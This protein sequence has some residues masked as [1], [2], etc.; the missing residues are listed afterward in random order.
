MLVDS[1][2]HLDA[3]E[4][5]GDRAAVLGAARAAGVGG[6]LVPGVERAGFAGLAALA[7]AEA[8]IAPAYGIHPLF[9]ARAADVDLEALEDWLVRPETV[10]VGE[11][12]LDGFVPDLPQPR[13]T[14]FCERQLQLAERHGLPVV[15]HVRR[16]VEDIIRLLRRR[17]LPGGIAHAFNGSR[18]QADILIGMGFALG[19]GGAMSF[20]GSKRI[21]QLAATLPLTAIV[22]ETDAPDIPPEWGQGQRNEPRNLARYAEILAGLRGI[23]VEEVA[24]TTTANALRAVPGLGRVVGC[25]AASIRFE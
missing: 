19:F 20:A 18:Q 15:L 8:D 9:V 5:D 13:L 4:F 22:L 21:R 10:A 17:S 24:A 23:P 14:Q 2:C 6:F 11:I 1:H 12:G 25:H 3:A 7:A 16:A